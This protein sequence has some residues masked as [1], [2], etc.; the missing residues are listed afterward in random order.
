MTVDELLLVCNSCW[1]D[2]DPGDPFSPPHKAVQP[3]II[4]TVTFFISIHHLISQRNI[5]NKQRRL[6]SNTVTDLR[7]GKDVFDSKELLLC[8]SSQKQKLRMCFQTGRSL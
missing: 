3:E 8:N 1:I 2:S 7:S 6:K 4:I 5:Y